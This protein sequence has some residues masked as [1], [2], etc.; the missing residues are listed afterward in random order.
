M[1]TRR[2][3]CHR[4]G[5]LLAGLSSLHS[6]PEPE[7]DAATLEILNLIVEKSHVLFE[8]HAFEQSYLPALLARPRQ[9]IPLTQALD[10]WQ[11]VV[12]QL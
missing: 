3:F 4:S 12:R 8:M 1:E 6:P 5:L 10:R 9:T 2:T 7:G 11:R